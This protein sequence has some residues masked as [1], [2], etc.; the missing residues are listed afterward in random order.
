MKH[1]Q[2]DFCI[3]LPI[4]AIIQIKKY[5]TLFWSMIRKRQEPKMKQLA[6]E[7]NFI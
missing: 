1:L 2:A 5:N 7:Q 3:N 4:K 6:N